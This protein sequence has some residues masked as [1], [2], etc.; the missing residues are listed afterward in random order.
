GENISTKGGLAQSVCFPDVVTLIRVHF[1]SV[2]RAL[3]PRLPRSM[4]DVEYFDGIVRNAIKDFVGIAPERHYVNTR[5]TRSPACTCRPPRNVS[6]DAADAPFDERC[7]P[8]IM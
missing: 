3:V 8:W 4:M 5:A 1:L 6:N 7:D 2:L